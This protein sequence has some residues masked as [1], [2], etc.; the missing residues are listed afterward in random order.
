[1]GHPLVSIRFLSACSAFQ[2]IPPP[3]RLFLACPPIPQVIPFWP[4]FS[5]ILLSLLSFIFFLSGC[6]HLLKALIFNSGKGPNKEHGKGLMGCAKNV[7][8]DDAKSTH[9]PTVLPSMQG[10]FDLIFSSHPHNPAGE[11][12]IIFVDL[13]E[14]KTW[15]S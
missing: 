5:S 6:F 9:I 1:M 12:G 10:S 11:V 4:L 7:A 2:L 13:Y 8:A 14:T 3:Y 15:L